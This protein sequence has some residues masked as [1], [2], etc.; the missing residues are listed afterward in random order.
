MALI[1]ILKDNGYRIQAYTSSNLDDFSLKTMFFNGIKGTDYI[2]QLK[3]SVR[4]DSYVISELIKSIRTERNRS[5]FFKFVFLTSSHYGY[6]YPD[7][8]A[9]FHPTTLNSSFI[10]NK[11]TDPTPLLNR[12]KNSLHYCDA[13]FG[14]VLK[15]LKEVHLDE[16]TV[17]IITSDHAEEFNDKDQGYWGH[18][19]NFTR[20]QTSVPLIMF[21]PQT[22]TGNKQK[23]M[24]ML[25][26]RC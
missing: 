7:N 2:S 5:P 23:I 18:G 17:I 16:K 24:S 14:D 1:S 22:M 6:E 15:A 26:Q 8:H 11:H 4:D 20:Y 3:G 21:L 13:L 25:Y 10:F 9:I 19:S 12:Y